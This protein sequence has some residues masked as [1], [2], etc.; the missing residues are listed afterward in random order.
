MKKPHWSN[1]LSFIITT[2]AFAIGL[3]NI[4]R[5]PYITG[6]G[7]GGA[8]LLIYLGLV[9]LIGIPILL[10]EIALGR[11]S[12]AQPLKG[13]GLLS[14]KK[15]WNGLGWLSVI[16]CLLIMGYYVMILSWVLIYFAE[17]LMG[18]T[19]VERFSDHFDGIVSNQALVF[20]VILGIMLLAGLIVK[21]G[22]QKG[23]E[24]YSKWMMIALIFI[25]I[26]IAIWASTL[27]KALDAYHWYLYP[28]F[29]KIS[30]N[31]VIVALGQLFFSIGIGMAIAF[32]FGSYTS[33]KENLITSTLWIVLLDTI[34][35]ILA[36]FMIFPAIFTLGMAPDSG[37]NLIFITMA[38][39]FSKITQGQIVGSAFF[40]LLFF[41]GFT[42][43]I[44]AIQGLKDSFVEK[45][46]MSSSR[47]LWM[48]I[49]II[50]LISLPCVFSYVDKP[51]VF[52]G[53]TF[54]E[55]ID[56]LTSIIMLPLGGLLIVLF[57]GYIVGPQKLKTHISS[58]AEHFRFWKYWSLII[59]V[60]VPFS[61]LVILLNSLF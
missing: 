61:V 17:N 23:L 30:L 32:A 51:F 21:G 19:Q 18:T 4:W 7:G 49:G 60:I 31:V 57:A 36:G 6:E 52:L 26:A 15:Y 42:S 45:F 37:P 5:F 9:F 11:M 12:Q 33:P 34:F 55:F 14:G 59:K 50:I 35:A 48:V 43:L 47:A 27:E 13:Y 29:S 56:Y 44:A 2:A 22:L 40:L 8:F 10:T 46:D 41:G 1:R 53:F 38:T 25:I 16:A 58:G 28:D 24:R 20:P 54:Y 3:G 39:V